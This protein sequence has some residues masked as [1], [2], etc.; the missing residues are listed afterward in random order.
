MSHT[1]VTIYS[2]AVRVFHHVTGRQP[3]PSNELMFCGRLLRFM[4]GA[5]SVLCDVKLAAAVVVCC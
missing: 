3:R 5:S 2:E 1:T 4:D